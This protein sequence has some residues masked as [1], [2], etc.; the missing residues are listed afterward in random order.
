MNKLL[1]IAISLLLFAPSYVLSQNIFGTIIDN[2]QLPIPYTNIALK[3]NN[4]GTCTNADGTFELDIKG[5]SSDTL[6]VSSIGYNTVIIPISKYKP[7]YNFGNIILE[8]K[9]FEID[10]ITITPKLTKIKK[11]KLGLKKAGN[12]SFY[13]LFGDEICT[14][15]ENSLHKEVKLSAINIHLVKREEADYVADL[16]IKIY[17]FDKQKNSP[18]E[19][20]YLEN[21]IVSPE[22]KQQILSIPVED[23][24]IFVS[25]DGICIGVE[26]M[27]KPDNEKKYILGPGLKYSRQIN[28]KITWG[29]FRNR[30][31]RLTSFDAYGKIAN[32]LITIDVLYTKD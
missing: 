32:A 20:K 8:K 11:K 24:S 29:N 12:I 30:G 10:E 16:N 9:F 18:G 1:L 3:N 19:L 15:I 28:K 23:K 2:N 5:N 7:N 31:W 13:T 4:I 26:W 22:N 25:E 6:I 17:K 27:G 14:F 21:I